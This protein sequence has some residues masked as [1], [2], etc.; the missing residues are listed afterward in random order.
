MLSARMTAVSS[1][2]LLPCGSPPYSS[3]SFVPERSS[4]PQPPGP[5]LPLHAP[6]V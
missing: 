4:A 5:G 3:R 1:I 6:S 2:R